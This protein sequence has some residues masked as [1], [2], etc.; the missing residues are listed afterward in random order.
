MVRLRR[1]P[2]RQASRS[3]T[4]GRE[5]AKQ[6]A[7]DGLGSSSCLAGALSPPPQASVGPKTRSAVRNTDLPFHNP[8]LHPTTPIWE[9]PLDV[10][11]SSRHVELTT[12][13]RTAA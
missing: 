11:V 6:R 2:C 13:L 5:G 9:D 1:K 8:E 10:T 12:A 3:A 7:T 4:V